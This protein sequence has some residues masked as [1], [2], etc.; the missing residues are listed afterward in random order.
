MTATIL[1]DG[2]A[3]VELVSL[4]TAKNAL[5]GRD[6]PPGTRQTQAP[7]E[8]ARLPRGRQQPPVAVDPLQ[9]AHTAVLKGNVGSGD[10]VPHGPGP[11]R[12]PSR[13]LAVI[14]STFSGPV[15]HSSV[16]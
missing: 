6:P 4:W 10:Q 9:Q 7:G 3:T 1:H 13:V 12:G 5:V 2:V 11:L 15:H 14:I 16:P 8:T